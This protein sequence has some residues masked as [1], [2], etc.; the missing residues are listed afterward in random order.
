M[1]YLH[2]LNPEMSLVYPHKDS[3]IVCILC[4]FFSHGKVCCVSLPPAST[5]GPLTNSMVDQVSCEE[6]MSAV[7]VHAAIFCF[8]S[9]LHDYGSCLLC[10]LLNHPHRDGGDALPENQ[11]VLFSVHHY[12]SSFLWP[13]LIP[14]TQPPSTIVCSIRTSM[15]LASLP[16]RDAASREALC[17]ECSLFS[18]LLLFLSLA[19]YLFFFPP[20]HCHSGILFHCIETVMSRYCLF[21]D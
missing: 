5:M 19:I 20:T 1:I 6:R 9:N 16:S 17:L 10:T 13:L 11:S 7:E 3:H 12:H 4:V 8:H 2:T 18:S 14:A 21:C 15:H